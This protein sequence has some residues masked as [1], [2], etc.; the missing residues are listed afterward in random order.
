LS[1]G[2]R[3]TLGWQAA[4]Q[5]VHNVPAPAV[6]AVLLCASLTIRSRAPGAVLALAFAGFA[7]AML[8]DEAA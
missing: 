5:P 1:T 8:V 6:I 7:S 3:L 2:T 4:R